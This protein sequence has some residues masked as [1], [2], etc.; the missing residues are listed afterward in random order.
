[1]NER[2][3]DAVVRRIARMRHKP[4]SVVAEE[5]WARIQARRSA[6]AGAPAP[7]TGPNRKRGINFLTPTSGWLANVRGMSVRRWVNAATAIAMA[8]AAVATAQA[9]YH[10]LTAR[11]EIPSP[12]TVAM[13]A[14]PPAP[15]LAGAGPRLELPVPEKQLA[16]DVFAGTTIAISPDGDRIA[17]MEATPSGDVLSVRPTDQFGDSAGH[18]LV[19][20]SG[21]QLWMPCFSPDG[22]WVAF[23]DGPWIKKV[24]VDSGPAVTLARLPA[25]PMGLTW[26]AGGFLVAGGGSLGLF[27][28]PERG[29]VVRVRPKA[30]DEASDRWPLV[31]PDG[32]TIVYASVPAGG[33]A[34]R[35]A[36]TSVDN[37][38][39]SRL[40]IPGTSPLA[41]LNGQVVYATEAGEL[42]A[43]SLDTARGTTGTA[44]VFVKGVAMDHL[45]AAKAALS[46][47]GTLVYRTGNAKIQ[48]LLVRGDTTKLMT[49]P[50]NFSTPRFSPDGQ[51]VAFTVADGA[52]VDVWVYDRA[53]QTLNRITN[54]GSSQRPEWTSDGRRVLYV[55]DRGATPGLWWQPVD[56]SAPAELLYAPSEGDPFEG[57]LSPD[58]SWLAYRTGP[59]GKPRQSIFAVQLGVDR[60]S[61][62]VAT[63]IE[64]RIS[65]DGR[66]LAYESNESALGVY[67]QPFPTG[68]SRQR[69]ST[70][71]DP[72]WAASGQALYYRFGPVMRVDI[73]TDSAVRV[74]DRRPVV[75]GNYEAVP[76]HQDYDVSP[77][78]SEFLMLR[79]VDEPHIIVVHNWIRELDAAAARKRVP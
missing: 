21:S 15:P 78:G 60:R 16:F 48:P 64:P 8:T 20:V 53:R 75:A 34:S 70:G 3:I 54:N 66:W 61:I 2:E 67:I 19:V 17:Y 52:A 56:R 72:L 50:R 63:G 10:R 59:W 9:I 26:G 12:A 11:P 23:A 35:L 73:S 76:S 5:T 22:R 43:V 45:G 33:F 69:V 40:N 18:P 36:L 14:E 71:T 13:T 30:N 62:R 39:R 38:K 77:D 41:F 68:G 55:T 58:G 31:L 28:I 25:Q 51:R 7:L 57:V 65:P 79:R 49:E 47:T 6:V 32:K 27:V 29:G 1:M 42:A 46:P 44:A 24:P 74:G 4:T 37:G